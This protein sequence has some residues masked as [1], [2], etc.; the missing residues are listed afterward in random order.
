MLNVIA[1]V[2]KVVEI[3]ELKETSGATKYSN[4]ALSIDRSF[5]NAEGA[6]ES[7]TIIVSLWRGVAELACEACKVGSIVSIKGRIQSREY[8]KDGVIYHNYD[9]IAEK[10]SF[11]NER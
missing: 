9:I 6:Y 4:I 11:I 10:L 8:E 1:L 3:P 5:K 2:G 7:D